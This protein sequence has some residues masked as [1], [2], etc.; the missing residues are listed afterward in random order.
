M[1]GRRATCMKALPGEKWPS[2]THHRRIFVKIDIITVVM[3]WR[4]RDDVSVGSGRLLGSR[5]RESFR[6]AASDPVTPAMPK[7]A[8]HPARLAA[9]AARQKKWFGPQCPRHGEA[10]HHTSSGQCVS[11]NRARSAVQA[12]LKSN[13]REGYVK[14][15]ERPER[16]AALAR[17]ETIYWGPLCLN[18]HAGKRANRNRSPRYT[19]STHCVACAQNRP[20][21][22]NAADLTRDM[23]ADAGTDRHQPGPAA[24]GETSRA[25]RIIS[26]ITRGLR[27]L[28][29]ETG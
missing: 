23:V 11:C 19:R 9:L 27:G 2:F 22:K 14:L 1:S 28:G 16:L 8:Q 5:R 7:F 21:G 13:R 12:V 18:G 4:A 15:C 26:R 25:R 17:G 3:P 24:S 20:K 10:P 6:R 29:G